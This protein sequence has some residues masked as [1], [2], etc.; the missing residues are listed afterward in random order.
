MIAPSLAASIAV[1]DNRD[2][3]VFNLVRYLEE[4]G[5]ECTV[6]A[7]EIEP[8]R[9][10]EFDGVMISPGPGAPKDAGNSVAII[11]W[12]FAQ[13]MPLIGIC[14]GMQAIAA[15][16]GGSVVRAERLIH[17]GTSKIDHDGV[18]IFEGIPQ[19]FNATRYHSLAVADLPPTLVVTAHSDDGEVMALRHESEEIVGVQFHPE[20]VLTEH[21]HQL[22][23]NWLKSLEK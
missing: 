19:H 10:A 11:D 15:A 16:F 20:A 6:F 23:Q 2:S 21:G 3:F 12:S 13:K 22:L 7:N 17:G 14:L 8:E 1:I 9:L 5:A 18:G 4:L